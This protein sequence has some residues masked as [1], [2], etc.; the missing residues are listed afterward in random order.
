MQSHLQEG[1]REQ[2]AS[3]RQAKS[4]RNVQAPR[5]SHHPNQETIMKTLTPPF[6]KLDHLLLCGL[7]AAA[8]IAHAAIAFSDGEMSGMSGMS[9]MDGK[10]DPHAAHQQ[11]MMKMQDIV[12]QQ[13]K[14]GVVKK[15][16]NYTVPDVSLIREDGTRVSFKDEL[17]DGKPVIMD[18]IFTSCTTIC[19]VLSKTFSMV[20][21]EL[22]ADAEKVHLISVSI[23]PEQDT[24][25]RLADYA[26]RFKAGPEWHFY[27]GTTEAS[28]AAQKAFDAYRGDK[29]NHEPVTFIRRAPGDPWLRME[30]FATADEVVHEYHQL[31]MAKTTM[32]ENMENMN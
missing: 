17:N 30:G 11:M 24:P 16:L 18:F 10:T 29:M 31:G 21:N 23:D 22:G 4:F 26:R 6:R 19:P 5:S 28:I 15:E 27:T 25:A 2:S 12:K 8:L 13:L 14:R 9:G 1:R 32:S 7:V 20:Q 3:A